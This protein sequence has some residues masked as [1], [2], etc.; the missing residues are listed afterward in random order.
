MI[1]PIPTYLFQAILVVSTYKMDPIARRIS[2]HS[3]HAE[4]LVL[5]SKKIIFDNA[6]I[7]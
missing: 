4:F 6:K 7:I 1:C 3:I 2:S 5:A